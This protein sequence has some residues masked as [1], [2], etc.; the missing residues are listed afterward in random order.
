MLDKAE[1]LFHWLSNVCK[2]KNYVFNH[3]V[4]ISQNAIGS[5]YQLERKYVCL[6]KILQDKMTALKSNEKRGIH[7]RP[8]CCFYAMI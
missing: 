8:D 6:T 2:M 1:N 7:F 4:L 3:F 5:R